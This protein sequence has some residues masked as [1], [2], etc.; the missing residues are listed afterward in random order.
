MLNAHSLNQDYLSWL[1]SNT[2]FEQL[3]P[4][5]VRIDSPFTDAIDDEIVMYA[6]QQSDDMILLTDDGWTLNNLAAHGI[7]FSRPSHRQKLL[8][9]QLVA[10]GVHL[11]DGDLIVHS[12]RHHFA[13]A[14]HRLL[15]AILFINDMFT[16]APTEA[17]PVFL[18]DVAHFLMENNIRTNQNMAYVGESGLIHKFDFSIPGINQIPAKLIK[19]LSSANN[20]LLAKATLADIEQTRPIVPG[21]TKFYVF[22]NDTATKH[23]SINPDILSL[24]HLNQIV[25]LLY[26]HRTDYLAD[27]TR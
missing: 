21:P 20:S 8:H 23:K 6:L 1:D 19:V 4:G 9:N 22:L 7:T 25:P 5:T 2:T 24:F 11:S 15:Q 3:N 13:E 16:L 27:L 10:Y 26:S 17:A 12:E 18:D 14:K